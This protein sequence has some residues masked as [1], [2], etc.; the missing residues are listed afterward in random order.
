MDIDGGTCTVHMG[1][2]T[3]RISRIIT[4]FFTL[5]PHLIFSNTPNTLRYKC[6]SPTQVVSLFIT[7]Y[8]FQYEHA[9]QWT[10][11]LIIC[12]YSTSSVPNAAYLSNMDLKLKRFI[13]TLSSLA[14][15]DSPGTDAV[16]DV[17]LGSCQTRRKYMTYMP[18]HPSRYAPKTEQNGHHTDCDY[19]SCLTAVDLTWEFGSLATRSGGRG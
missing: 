5:L 11:K 13:V 19:P 4:A 17:T 14:V 15:H 3:R 16:G 1:W 6:Q 18:V 10:H 8:P 12:L 9:L 2:L 7:T